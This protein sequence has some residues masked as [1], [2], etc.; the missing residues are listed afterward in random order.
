MGPGAIS[1]CPE[2]CVAGRAVNPSRAFGLWCPPIPDWAAPDRRS[3]APLPISSSLTLS[4]LFHVP[5][6]TPTRRPPLCP[7]GPHRLGGHLALRRGSPRGTGP[8]HASLLRRS[9]PCPGAALRRHS[10]PLPTR[11]A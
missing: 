10:Q 6:L 1:N 2:V 3:E 7:G 11:R 9:G 5:L 4:P 8:P